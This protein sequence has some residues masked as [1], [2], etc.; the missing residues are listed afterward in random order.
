M[1]LRSI[2]LFALLVTI[3]I[4]AP[5]AAALAD[6]PGSSLNVNYGC[7]MPQ[8]GLYYYTRT[9]LGDM[10][11]PHCALERGQFE[12]GQVFIRVLPIP[13]GRN[14]YQFQASYEGQRFLIMNIRLSGVADMMGG[15]SATV[16]RWWTE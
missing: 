16:T 10:V 9:P 11:I 8:F 15:S 1:L 14:D 4:A 2:T 7:E 13:G 6:D 3:A 12:Y 5:A